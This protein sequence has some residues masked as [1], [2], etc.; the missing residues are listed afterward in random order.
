MADP[1]E[2]KV[3]RLSCGSFDIAN[4]VLKSGGVFSGVNTPAGPIEA[5][6]YDGLLINAYKE[7]Y[8]DLETG[9]K[10]S[11]I[12]PR[13]VIGYGQA[14]P[15][16]ITDI[17][18][19]EQHL[20]YAAYWPRTGT[21][22]VYYIAAPSP[23][24]IPEGRITTSLSN[25]TSSLLATGLSYVDATTT[26]DIRVGGTEFF[27]G[28]NYYYVISNGTQRPWYIDSTP[29]ATQ[30]ADVDCPSGSGTSPYIV[31]MD[32]AL[33]IAKNNAIHNSEFGSITNWPGYFRTKEQFP[34]NIEVLVRHKNSIAAISRNSVEFFFNAGYS[35]TSPLNRQETYASKVGI[36]P[37][38]AWG[39]PKHGTIEDTIYFIGNNRNEG[40]ALYKIENF[41]VHKVSS[42][43]IDKIFRSSKLVTNSSLSLTTF[44]LNGQKFVMI[45]CM[46]SNGN[47][48][49]FAN[50]Y[51]DIS[52]VYND[53][54]NSWSIWTARMH[55]PEATPIPAFEVDPN[56]EVYIHRFPFNYLNTDNSGLIYGPHSKFGGLVTISDQTT[57]GASIFGRG[58][59]NYDF[60]NATSTTYPIDFLIRTPIIDFG[61][62]KNK[63]IKKMFI[64]GLVSNEYSSSTDGEVYVFNQEDKLLL[65]GSYPTPILVAL[66]DEG[67]LTN[68]STGR[69]FT[70]E[71]QAFGG[72]W[73]SME[74]FEFHYIEGEQ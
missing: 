28:T 64:T 55:D 45:H 69:K 50:G 46:N 16:P 60:T 54:S 48:S 32:G 9:R 23:S 18:V 29:T 58:I 68:L 53:T 70:I 67:M 47:A 71:L 34:E 31:Y 30:I 61:S 15:T 10:K 56:N 5:A 59:P 27:D 12:R 40:I 20:R 43:N 66:K 39:F 1:K 49:D 37:P 25:Y 63:H 62:R 17:Y 73:Q 44:T 11:R 13:P 72:T 14:Y 2:T 22:I 8:Y 6:M 74:D 21:D 19:E 3:A 65:G 26:G 41:K 36:V 35:G 4:S 33:F 57:P 38:D 24:F 7:E 51:A 42:P 52:L